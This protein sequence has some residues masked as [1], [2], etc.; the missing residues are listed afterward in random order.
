MDVTHSKGQVVVKDLTQGL[1][2]KRFLWG[3]GY[4]FRGFFEFGHIFQQFYSF[5]TAKNSILGLSPPIPLI[6]P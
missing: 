6:R 1:S 4:I 3:R 2:Q 5:I